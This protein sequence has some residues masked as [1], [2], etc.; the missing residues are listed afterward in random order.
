MTIKAMTIII[1][2]AQFRDEGKGEFVDV[3]GRDADIAHDV[4]E[5]TTYHCC[6]QCQIGLSYSS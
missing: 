5:A 4:D 1:V 3:L 2:G 6:K